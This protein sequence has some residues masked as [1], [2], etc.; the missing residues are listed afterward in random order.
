MST[1]LN[2]N[3]VSQ[4]NSLTDLHVDVPLIVCV[5]L[6]VCFSVCLC[7][8]V[9]KLQALVNGSLGGA[10]ASAQ[11]G[12]GGVGGGGGGG[13][14]GVGPVCLPRRAET[15][16]GFD[17]HQMHGSKSKSAASTAA[18]RLWMCVFVEEL[19]VTVR[20]PHPSSPAAPQSCCSSVTG[21]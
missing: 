12:G 19:H 1:G 21:L 13:G 8:T 14:G 5:S 3:T 11:E 20:P 4:D 16:G 2:C 18:G 10:M 17:S 6:C 7:V 15:F 9:E